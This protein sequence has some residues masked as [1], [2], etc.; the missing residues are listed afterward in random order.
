MCFEP[1]VEYISQW[2]NG[3]LEMRT[4]SWEKDGEAEYTTRLYEAMSTP[5]KYHDEGPEELYFRY[6]QPEESGLGRTE[7]H[8]RFS[9]D[10]KRP[11]VILEH[12]GE[13]RSYMDLRPGEQG[14]CSYQTAYGE[15]QFNYGCSWVKWEGDTK[16]G[17]LYFRYSIENPY[18][19]SIQHEFHIHY[20]SSLD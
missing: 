6:L 5:F 4:K 14:I 10:K 8:L 19:A 13:T 15:I 1:E 16:E 7:T 18:E 20:K 3:T 2:E 12:R 11:Y 17:M 9:L